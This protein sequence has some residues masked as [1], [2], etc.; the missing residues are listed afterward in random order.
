MKM[1]EEE[2]LQNKS[3]DTNDNSDFD[4]LAQ[5]MHTILTNL[6]GGDKTFPECEVKSIEDA[7]KM[8]DHISTIIIQ[9]KINSNDASDNLVEVD[10]QKAEISWQNFIEQIKKDVATLHRNITYSE[11]R[12]D[13][14]LREMKSYIEEFSK[15]DGYSCSTMPDPAWLDRYQE[16]QTQYSLSMRK[17]LCIILQCG[18][19]L[20]NLVKTLIGDSPTHSNF[21]ATLFS[22]VNELK[23]EYCEYF[24]SQE[25]QGSSFSIP[26]ESNSIP[27][28]DEDIRYKA[29]ED[30]NRALKEKL[31]SIMQ[32]ND[33]LNLSEQELE[34]ERVESL[35]SERQKVISLSAT[36]ERLREE[37]KEEKDKKICDKIRAEEELEKKEKEFRNQIEVLQKALRLLEEEFSKLQ[38]KMQ[39]KEQELNN[40]KN[41]KEKEVKEKEEELAEMNL[42]RAVVEVRPMYSLWLYS[43]NKI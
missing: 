21:L 33:K 24:G 9:Q 37:L 1:K 12:S 34:Q 42:S 22:S 43:I 31:Q 18:S 7:N 6:N 20:C 8:L 29:L 41:I 4:S 35:V 2:K 40:L 11:A 26:L 27:S 19:T 15:I 39:S 17:N 28:S 5:K 25:M 14:I 23:G 10:S 38:E 16:L 30:E 13:I 32:K 36:N 3:Q